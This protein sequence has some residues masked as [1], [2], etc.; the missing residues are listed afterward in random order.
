MRSTLALTLVALTAWL[1]AADPSV[2]ATS[3]APAKHLEKRLCLL[4][5][6]LGGST[7]N[8]QTDPNNWCVLSPSS[9]PRRSSSCRC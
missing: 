5:L 2:A 8:L 1:A 7:V 9:S 6:C 4:G 3:P